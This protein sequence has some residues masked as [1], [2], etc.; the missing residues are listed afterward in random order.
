MVTSEQLRAKGVCRCK[1]AQGEI[2]LGVVVVVTPKAVGFQDGL[3]LGG[4]LHGNDL[5]HGNDDNDIVFGGVGD[6]EIS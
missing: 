4:E 6:D 5:I 2:S 1:T 3:D